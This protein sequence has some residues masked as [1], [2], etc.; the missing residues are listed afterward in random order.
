MNEKNNWTLTWLKSYGM[1]NKN[2]MKKVYTENHKK[3]CSYQKFN[4]P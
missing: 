3:F 4:I 2:M 1:K